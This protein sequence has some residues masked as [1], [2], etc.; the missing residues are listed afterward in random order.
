MTSIKNGFVTLTLIAK[1]YNFGLYV[2]NTFI[3]DAVWNKVS[4]NN[5]YIIMP[6]PVNPA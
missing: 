5:E 2:N 4:L 3:N 1:L 6:I